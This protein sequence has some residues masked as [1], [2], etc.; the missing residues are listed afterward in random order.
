[1]TTAAEEAAHGTDAVACWCCGNEYEADQVVR[2]GARPEVAVCIGCAHFL[3][4]R[5][6]EHVPATAAAR[7]VRG[8][9][10]SVRGAVIQHKL[11]EKPVIGKALRWLDRHLP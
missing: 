4:R 10:R 8:L 3:R 6:K 5:A 2:L 11:G 9:M 1:M 7:R